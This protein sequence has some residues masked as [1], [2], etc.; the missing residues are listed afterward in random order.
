[1]SHSQAPSD[2]VAWI[3]TKILIDNA[4][5]GCAQKENLGQIEDK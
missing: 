5:T 4:V 1:M 2:Q 3:S